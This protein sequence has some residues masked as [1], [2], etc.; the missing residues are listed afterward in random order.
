MLRMRLIHWFYSL[1]VN[2]RADALRWVDADGVKRL[3]SLFRHQ[4][5]YGPGYFS[6]CKYDIIMLCAYVC[7]VSSSWSIFSYF[8]C[9]V[10]LA[11]QKICHFRTS[12]QFRSV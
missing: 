4:R 8:F 11:F 10:S 6:N 3:V 1:S 12:D 5:L 7:S 9:L 2:E